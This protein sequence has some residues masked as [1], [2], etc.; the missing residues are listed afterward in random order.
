MSLCGG[1]NLQLN[2]KA[3]TVCLSTVD[4]SKF[5]TSVTLGGGGVK[6]KLDVA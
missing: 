4:R 5:K 2:S 1:F 6:V 3:A